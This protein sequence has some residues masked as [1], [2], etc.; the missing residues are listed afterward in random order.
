VTLHSALKPLSAIK[1]GLRY[2]MFGTGLAAGI[3]VDVGAFLRSDPRLA[4]PDLQFSFM[5]GFMNGASID[6]DGYTLTLWHLRPDSRGSIA[7]RSTDP[8]DSP[9]I[10]PNYFSAPK[11]I[12]ALRQGIKI[13]R[14][15]LAQAPFES[16]RGAEVTPGPSVRSDDE[17]DAHLRQT[18]TGLWHPVGTAS[19]GVDDAAVVDAELRVRG[20]NGL[21]VAD[22]S[23]MPLI[24][25]SNTNAPVIMIAEKAAD[26]ILG[27][28]RLPAQY[29]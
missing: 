20:V 3:G 29:V 23:V 28:P 8:R 22:A 16:Y 9:L 26:M 1:I 19:M 10:Q 18:A 12:V 2:L 14:Q 27:K 13:A 25:S 5:N 4:N 7:L 21:R 17:I 6:R 11:E 24:V 15:V